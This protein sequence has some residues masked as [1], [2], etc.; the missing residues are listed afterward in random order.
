MDYL[1]E[2]AC[3]D[4]AGLTDL[5]ETPQSPVYNTLSYRQKSEHK[6]DYTCHAISWL[7]H[8]AGLEVKIARLTFCLSRAVKKSGIGGRG[9]VLPA[10]GS[11]APGTNMKY[12]CDAKLGNSA[13]VSASRLN[14]SI[15]SRQISHQVKD[16]ENAR[17][18]PKK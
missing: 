10:H 3:F 14:D 12:E 4:G 17:R 5:L 18:K 9:K 15:S 16:I 7:T 2:S 6:T 11:L 8:L 1:L 13:I